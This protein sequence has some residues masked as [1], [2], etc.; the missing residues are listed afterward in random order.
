MC[1][2][3]GTYRASWSPEAIISTRDLEKAKCTFVRML[4]TLGRGPKSDPP[5]LMA[6]CFDTRVEIIKHKN[7]IFPSF[8]R[9]P[10]SVQ[11][12]VTSSV[13]FSGVLDCVIGLSLCLLLWSYNWWLSWREALGIFRKRYVFS[14][15]RLNRGNHE[16]LKIWWNW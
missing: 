11:L 10:V 2:S 16:M 1:Y 4:I 8:E 9:F 3:R 13:M 15:D 12:P 6:F 5:W 7:R 14:K